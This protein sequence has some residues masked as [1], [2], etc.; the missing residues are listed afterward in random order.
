[1]CALIQ[2]EKSHWKTLKMVHFMPTTRRFLRWFGLYPSENLTRSG[3]KDTLYIIVVSLPLWFV[4]LTS[5]AYFKANIKTADIAVITDNMYTNFIFTMMCGNYF[6][7]TLRKFEIREI[8][9]EMEAMLKISKFNSKVLGWAFLKY[10]LFIAG[11]LKKDISM[12]E[13]ANNQ[14]ESF[15]KKYTLWC[16]IGNM[17]VNCFPFLRPLFHYA[18]GKY[19]FASWYTPYKS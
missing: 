14:S 17:G 8:I 19:S 16:F 10:E 12:Y 7:L 1:M 9:D 3:I 5:Y 18:T 15:I 2:E 11:L 4:L 6:L 13:K